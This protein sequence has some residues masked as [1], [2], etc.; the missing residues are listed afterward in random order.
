MCNHPNIK[1]KLKLEQIDYEN[2]TYAGTT[3]LHWRNN[4]SNLTF[5]IIPSTDLHDPTFVETPYISLS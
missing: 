1:L 4:Q 5:P 3:K 2:V